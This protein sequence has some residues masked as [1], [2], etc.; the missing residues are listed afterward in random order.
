MGNI[1]GNPDEAPEHLVALDGFWMDQY[2]VTNEEFER[3]V[4]ATG[5][6]TVAEKAPAAE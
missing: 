6:G 4:K 5:Y 1:A 2:E 3:F